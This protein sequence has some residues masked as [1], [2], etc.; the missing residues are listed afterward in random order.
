MAKEA[1][2]VKV[3][4]IEDI[5]AA[6][7]LTT[8]TIP[9]PEWGGSVVIRILSKAEQNKVRD[10]V[11]GEA[12]NMGAFEQE[13]FTSAMVSPEVDGNTYVLLS[14][15]SSLVMERIMREIIDLNGMGEDAAK[16]KE[17]EFQG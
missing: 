2:E 13:L 14:Q 15:K 16:K 11:S 8:K 12:T 17:A 3:L 10:T 5:V 6:N 1:T 9:C 7:D 4:S